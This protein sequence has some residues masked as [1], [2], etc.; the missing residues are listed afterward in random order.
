MKNTVYT[1]DRCGQTSNIPMNNFK[2]EFGVPLKSVHPLPDLQTGHL[3]L[4][5]EPLWNEKFFN[6]IQDFKKN[7]KESLI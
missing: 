7:K 2:C 3:C 1:C 5:C 4:T 6:Q